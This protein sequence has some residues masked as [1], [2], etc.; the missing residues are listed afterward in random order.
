MQKLIVSMMRFS[1]ALTM[2]GVEQMQ[3][4]V[5]LATG[6]ENLD[7]AMDRF[8]SSM[9]DFSN[10]VVG[11]LGEDKKKTVESFTKASEDA[12]NQTMEGL[13]MANMDPGSFVEA[14]T[15]FVKKTTDSMVD[16]VSG[17]AE[18]AA[19]AA[20]EAPKRAAEVLSRARKT[21]TAKKSTGAKAK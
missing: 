13:N 21:S 12:L 9:D 1:S 17:R 7:D 11:S 19:E 6:K 20:G 8:K 14:T 2:L 3:N 10:A 5:G 18:D 16:F 15:D 4:S